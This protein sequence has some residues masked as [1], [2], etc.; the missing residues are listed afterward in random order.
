VK[1]F[2]VG[3][4][5]QPLSAPSQAEGWRRRANL[6]C[7]QC[8]HFGSRTGSYVGRIGPDSHV[9]EG[10][11]CLQR[12]ECGSSPASGTFSHVRGVFCFRCVHIF[13]LR[14]PLRPTAECACRQARL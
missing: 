13:P 6:G 8:P 10:A 2:I 12:E 7:G 5:R 14:V 1:I 9:S 11:Q 3:R 4:L